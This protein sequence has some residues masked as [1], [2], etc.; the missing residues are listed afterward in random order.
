MQQ[1]IDA[2]KVSPGAY[3]AMAGLQAMS[4]KA[5]WSGRCSNW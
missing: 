4:I 1:R 5:D 2:M 3:K